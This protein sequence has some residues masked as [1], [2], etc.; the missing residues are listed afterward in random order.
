MMRKNKFRGWHPTLLLG[1]EMK[2]KVF[3]ILGAGRIGTA[4]AIRAAAFGCKILYYSN[5][6]NDLLERK[7]GAKKVSLDTLLKKS[8]II[9]IHLPLNPKTNQLLDKKNLNY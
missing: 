9:S 4:T 6:K 3:G 7:S 5:N 2:N 1:V 8:D